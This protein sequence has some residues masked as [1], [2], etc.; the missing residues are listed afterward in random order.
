MNY[1]RRVV[2]I[3]ATKVEKYDIKKDPRYA[4]LIMIVRLKRNAYFV[5]E[6]Q[7]TCIHRHNTIRIIVKPV[8]RESVSFSPL[9]KGCVLSTHRCVPPLKYWFSWGGLVRLPKRKWTFERRVSRTSALVTKTNRSNNT[10]PRILDREAVTVRPSFRST[11]HAVW[12][13]NLSAIKRTCRGH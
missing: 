2:L 9:Q 5:N 10:L 11:F 8:S 13:R 7:I 12:T 6:Q 3:P 1:C 4:R